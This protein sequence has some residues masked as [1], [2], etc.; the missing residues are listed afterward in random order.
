MFADTLE[1]SWADRSRRSWTTLTSFGLE[2]L[3]VGLL[4]LVPLL[5]PEGLP[6]LRRLAT[7]IRAGRLPAEPTPLPAR[8][9]PSTTQSNFAGHMLMTPSHIPSV[10]AHVTDIAPPPQAGPSGPYVPGL[11]GIGGPNGVFGAAGAGLRP[12]MP[13]LP[14]PPAVHTIRVSHISEGN[15]IRKVQPVYPPLAR[16]ARIQGEVVLQ[17]MIS[18]EGTIENLQVV[19]GHPMLAGAAIDAVRQ[20]RYRPYILNN[21]PVEVETQITVKFSLSGN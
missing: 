17:A 18:K 14:P 13:I 7:P 5:R 9:Q 4:L 6:V 10:V 19:N 1:A 8:P 15:L 12:V 20:W 21:D 11:S 2:A 3:V 16:A